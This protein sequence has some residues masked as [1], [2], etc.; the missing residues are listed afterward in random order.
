V[1]LVPNSP[2]LY[3]PIDKALGHFRRY[4]KRELETKVVSTGFQPNHLFYGN[5]IGILGW[6]YRGILLKK[7]DLPSGQLRLYMLLKRILGSV[8]QWI[9]KFTGLSVVVVAH[10]K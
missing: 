1:V 10:K 6:F 5:A 3:S 9:E 7:A 2:G 4:T 8:E